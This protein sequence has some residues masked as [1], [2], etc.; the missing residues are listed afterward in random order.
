MKNNVAVIEEFK[1]RQRAQR[2]GRLESKP[3]LRELIRKLR[4]QRS[5]PMAE[6]IK[7]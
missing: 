6:R 5:K 4:A 3:T 1:A 2:N 7:K